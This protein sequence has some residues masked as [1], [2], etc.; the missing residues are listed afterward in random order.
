MNALR[1]SPRYNLLPSGDFVIENYNEAKPFASFFPGVAGPHGIPMWVFYVNRGQ[2]V[3]SIGTEDKDH[4]IMEFLPANRAYQLTSQQGFRTWLKVGEGKKI[5]I[6]EPFQNQ[7]LFQNVRRSQ[8]MI[9][10]PAELV[11]EEN[12]ESLALQFRAEFFN[13]PEDTYAGFVRILHVTNTGKQERRIEML[14]GLPLVIPFGVDNFNLLHMRRLVE[15]FV[16]CVNYETGIPFFKGRVK[17]EDRPDIV[18]I[19]EG[20]FYLG[21]VRKGGREQWVRPVVDPALVFG[22]VTDYTDPRLFLTRTPFRILDA[23]VLENRLPC[24]LGV[25]S[26]SLKPGETQTYYTII[27]RAASAD[28]LNRMARRIAKVEYIEAKRRQNG[29]IVERITQHNLVHSAWRPFDLYCRQNFLDNTLRGGLPVSF[30]DDRRTTV[31]HLYSRKHGDLE[32]DYN[33]YRLTP[34]PYSQGNGNFR[35]V[36][37]NRRCDLFINPDVQEDNLLH[38]F[39]LI[40]LDGFNPLVIK[41]ARF[42]VKQ[43]GATTRLLAKAFSPSDAKAVSA[44]L[45]NRRFMP[46]DLMAFVVEHGFRLRMPA[47]AFMGKLLA[48]CEKHQES[49][50]G[51]GFWTDHWTYNM[52]L[53]ENYLAVYPERLRRLLLQRKEFTFYDSHYVVMPRTEKYV[54]WDGKPMQLDAVRRSPEKEAL[55]RTR[56]EPIHTVR[57]DYGRGEIYRTTLLGKMLSLAVNKASSLDPFGVGIEMEADK[58]N[59]YDALNGLPGLFGSSLCETIE[60]KRLL[61]FLRDTA[62]ALRLAEDAGVALYEEAADFLHQL[63]GLLKDAQRGGQAADPFTFWDRA[64]TARESYRARTLLGVSGREETVSVSRMMEFIDLALWKLE[65]GLRKARDPKTGLPYTYFAH[66]PVKYCVI[67]QNGSV[68]TNPR[69]LPCFVALKFEQKPLPLFLEGIVH[70]LRVERNPDLARS[71]YQRVRQSGLFDRKLRMYKVNESLREQPYEI[72][73]ARTF[74]PGWL[75]NES[76]WMHMEFKYLLELLR[77]G[78]VEEF[79][80]DI[81][82]MLPPFMDPARYGR[83]ILENSSF[84]AS[85]A[86]PDRSI[87][88]MGF[89]ARLSGSTAEFIHIL[90]TLMAGEK[91][92]ILDERGRLTLRFSPLLAGEMFSQKPAE[93]VLRTDAGSSRVALPANSVSFMFLG[94]VL[95]TYRNPNAGIHLEPAP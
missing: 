50:P 4:A 6:Y 94:C 63:V 69:G 19:R 64:A 75:E 14:D 20:H 55:F 52:D 27:G 35:D 3:C 25:L 57:A 28:A 18:P 29:E 47:D 87:H 71:V 77:S 43:K 22:S 86:N 60:L 5:R 42:A 95:V 73:R 23:P 76:V 26:C 92:F 48:E 7:W 85:S 9:I 13:I 78:L 31:L 80:A 51:H 16:E 44:F 91:P 36:N 49:D 17:Q 74:S 38:F 54:V 89:V 56:H 82:T 62:H 83:S 79:Y 21:F 12:A 61:L 59:W 33:D 81:R 1:S 65:E 41:P 10:R 45:Q 70:Y 8:R 72:G 15:S 32:R 68:K 30:R 88:G 34:T 39:N 58:P 2:C 66:V 24:A 67:R 46:G 84:I 40:Q 53:L 11:L 90:Y 93:I 37:Q